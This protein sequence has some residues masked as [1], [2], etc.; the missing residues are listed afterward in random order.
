MNV[1]DLSVSDLANV[2]AETLREALRIAEG[3]EKRNAELE[4]TRPRCAC[5]EKATRAAIRET[6]FRVYTITDN[7]FGDKLS[8]D[9][10]PN[11]FG[12]EAPN[13]KFHNDLP[14]CPVFVSCDSENCE[15]DDWKMMS[16]KSF[17]QVVSW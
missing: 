17:F 9:R 5:G 13:D 7:R 10:T 16:Q 8:L 2:D 11:D 4:K 14:P 15:F 12:E 1:S 6:V 3:R